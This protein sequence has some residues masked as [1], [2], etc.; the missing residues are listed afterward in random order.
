MRIT[1]IKGVAPTNYK[2][3]T[4]ILNKYR[5]I[6]MAI[7]IGSLLWAFICII[8]MF[9]VFVPNVA[10]FVIFVII[11]PIIAIGMVQPIQNYH[12]NLEYILLLLKWRKR[13]RCFSNILIRKKPNSTNKKLKKSKKNK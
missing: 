13:T 1:D 2:K 6:D 12:N 5:P 3:G 11:L 9:F 10:F 4:L 8:L 7:M